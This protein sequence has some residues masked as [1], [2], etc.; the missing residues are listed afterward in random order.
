MKTLTLL[1]ASLVVLVSAHQ[2]RAVSGVTPLPLRYEASGVDLHGAVTSQTLE[3]SFG[4]NLLGLAFTDAN[5]YD[6]YSPPLL[7]SVT[8]TTNY[9]GGGIVA[10]T[11]TAPTSANDFQAVAIMVYYDYD[12]VTGV[13]TQI[14]N[15]GNA[16]STPQS[17]NHGKLAQWTL[18]HNPLSA[19]Y[20]IPAGHLVHVSL[21][22]ELIS[23]NPGSYGQL[24]YNGP[25]SATTIGL[26]PENV[27]LSGGWP[28]GGVVTGP[29]SI[30]SITALG[31][32]TVQLNCAGSSGGTYLI[33]VTPA[34]GAGA[35]WTCIST[36]VADTNGLF[37][38]IDTDAANHISRFYR[39]RTP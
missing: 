10:M 32:Q 12:P 14:A 22:V 2:A 35:S 24:L 7:T 17:V 18:I 8:L 20:T 28:F 37:Q 29:P 39:A 27:S 1:A 11:N 30:V 21:I 23:G 19:N 13:D 31:N 9:Q 38:F 15:A 4:T 26:L 5:I 25:S 6:F 16:I 36:N 3:G 33:A 34:L